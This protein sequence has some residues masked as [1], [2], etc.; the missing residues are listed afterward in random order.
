MHNK[1]KIILSNNLIYKEAELSQEESNIKIGTTKFCKIR[2]N[3]DLFFHD[4]EIEL[5]L[6]EDNWLINCIEG[7]YL[8]VDDIMKLNSKRLD[9]G[10]K[11]SLKFHNTNQ[12]AIKISYLIDF[13]NN[14][15]DWSRCVDIS[16]R[17]YIKIGGG[18]DCDIQIYDN[19]IKND[20][21]LIKKIHNQLFITEDKMQFGIYL[22]GIRTYKDTEI[23]EYDFF[24]L[25]E[26]S[27]YYKDGKLYTQNSDNL[28]LHHLPFVD[29]H[30]STNGFQYPLFNR[31]TRIKSVIPTE[32]IAILDPPEEPS[33]PRGNL[34]AQL[35]PAIIMLGVTIVLRGI[36]SSSGS[37]F[38]IYSVISMSL[39]IFTSAAGIIS[40]RKKYKKELSNRKKKYLF[41]IAE[42]QKLI[43]KYR[44]EELSILNDTYYALDKEKKMVQDFSSSLFE[45]SVE[46]TDFLEVRIGSGNQMSLRQIDYKP[47]EKFECSDE[48][49]AIPERITHEYAFIE[50]API[51]I[52]FKTCNAV[53][54]VGETEHLYQLMKNIVLDLC[55][56]HYYTDVQ[57]FFVISEENSEKISWT[58][59]LPHLTNQSL[60][61]RNIVCDAD[62]R[63]ILFE[64]LYKEFTKRE[65]ENINM[66]HLVILVLDDIGI[67]RHPISN[68]IEVAEN[69]G[70]TFVFFENKREFLPHGCTQIVELENNSNGLLIQ[71]QDYK[72]SVKFTCQSVDDI[73]AEEMVRKIAPVY[74][75]E[76]SLEGTLTK[77]ITLFELLDIYAVDDLDLWKRWTESKIYKSMAAPLGVKS[78]NDIVSL[79]L[80]EK[81]HGPHGLVAGTTG[82][83]KSEILQSYILSMA[84]LFHPYEVGF[85]IIDFKGGG[86][87]NQFKD[88]PHL[89]GAITN[90]DGREINRSL[91][92]IKAELKKRQA[93][94]A[95]YG[96]NHINAYIKLYKSNAAK[97]PLPHLILIVDEFAELKMDQPEFMK[98]LISAARIGRSLGV[99]LILATQKPSGVVDAQIWSNSKFKLCLKVQ[100]KEDSNEVLKTPLAAEIKEPGRA[101]LQVGNNEIFELFQSAYS[102]A[103][104]SN[105]SAKKK[106][107]ELYKV[108][109]SGRRTPIY[110]QKPEKE[111]EQSATQLEALVNFINQFC[112]DNKISPLPGI[113]LPPLQDNIPYPNSKLPSTVEQTN[114]QLGIYDDPDNQMQQE[115]TLDLLSGHTVIVG[116]SQ[117]GK[118]NLLQLIIRGI[119]DN[120]TPNEVSI[121]ILDFAS[122]ALKVFDKLNH[123]G[124]VIV[125]S[126][127]EK[128]KNFMRMITTEIKKRKELLSQIGIT[129]FVSY[130]QAG[131]RDLPHVLII[132]DNFLALKDLYQDYEDNI[133]GICR[134]GVS[135]GI[136][137]VITSIQTNGINYKYM[138]NLSNRI[139]LY[140][141][142]RDEYS[143]VFDRCRQEPKNIP[144]R[145]LMEKDKVIY[146]YQNYMA[147]EGEKEIDRVQSIKEYISRVIME[148]KDIFA[149]RIPEVPQILDYNYVKENLNP[150]QLKAYQ[151]PIG[152]DYD[153]VDYVIIDLLKSLTIG[154]TG[155]PQFGKTN[156]T[157]LLMNY[158]QDNLF[159][160]PSKVYLLDDYDKQLFEFSSSGIVEKY[161]VDV[162]DFEII[163]N[164][165]EEELQERMKLIQE[166]GLH[167]LEQL[168]LL[169]CVIQNSNLFTNDGVSKAVVD[170]FKRILKTYKQLKVCF[171]FTSL[172]NIAVP[173]SAPEFLKLIKDFK[174]IFVC[175]DIANLKLVEITAAVA[176][177][178]KKP[179]EI[180]DAYL[181]SEKGIQK[182]KIIH[183]EKRE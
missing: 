31:S 35:L 22:N 59:F 83:G 166:G 20:F 135:L 154:I 63:N 142:E 10:D 34:V 45:R 143:S 66:P 123:V 86:M 101:Y 75:E 161:S 139:C 51:T 8:S 93:L 37:T 151:V 162:N 167:S 36:M 38:V 29:I 118:T 177:L 47:Q 98:E 4:F 46:D 40:E 52:N 165:I 18:K 70:I 129:S 82:S 6:V 91:R 153:S 115:V 136:S 150:N 108:S 67:K 90:I 1:Y 107:F 64:Y 88:L 158:L 9:H 141:N 77:N 13:D 11:F 61:M 133:I 78:K 128:M 109:L 119:A 183:A 65:K 130:R 122:M 99:H 156:I 24:S 43:G 157:R 84:T 145:A 121:Y 72:K 127:D 112:L 147:F 97:I 53:G 132:I 54:I 60:G 81:Y 33:K 138:N 159:D 170:T 126:D 96:V 169:L 7:V 5:A 30:D 69:Y 23:R 114:V 110:I 95:E 25:M 175:D 42:K 152:I 102:G 15:N 106:K 16:Q 174:Y 48:L 178:Y 120:Y 180:G 131:Y 14:S 124:G 2:F 39:G 56:R 79:D 104:A 73:D 80:H 27:F 76:V 100:N 3:R 172:E 155:R 92:S 44:Y 28:K 137:L 32:P 111:K 116:S 89:I 55:T 12:E 74:C 117:Y 181:I 57:L 146:E 87:V 125:P 134:E 26:Y 164:E 41:Y 149:K 71:V 176:K 50:M 168:P 103:F 171:V 113:C 94:F 160:Y 17:E 58:R 173:Y 62:S 68:Y 163:L 144:G 85:V 21:I 140:C 179:I 148:Q 49:V 19:L 182:Q 105:E